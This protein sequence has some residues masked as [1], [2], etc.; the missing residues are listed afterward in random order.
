MR[1][2][3]NNCGA[4]LKSG[5]CE[6]CGTV[7]ETPEQIDVTCCGDSEPRLVESG[8]SLFKVNDQNYMIV[9]TTTR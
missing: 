1:T 6:Y 8:Q 3:C 2:N 9:Y 7:W 5:R 4:V